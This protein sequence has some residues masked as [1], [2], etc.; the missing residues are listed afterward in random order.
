[1][2]EH[3]LKTKGFMSEPELQWLAER[4]VESKVIVEIGCY[5]G[6]STRALADN[7]KGRVYCIDPWP[8]PLL[9]QYGKIAVASGNYVYKQFLR[10]F[11]DYIK[12]DKVIVHRGTVKDFPYDI[13]PDFIF[14]DGNHLEPAVQD[15]LK[16]A[17][18]ILKHGIIAGHDYANPDWPAVKKLVDM[19]FPTIGTEGHIWWTTLK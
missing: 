6:R 3:A 18:T 17:L 1:M 8:G 16:F 14:I 13:E 19:T 5:Y 12:A 4:A 9:N 7:T 11:D 10:S 2:I 15:D